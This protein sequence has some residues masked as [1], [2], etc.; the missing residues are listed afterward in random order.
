MKISIA[1][2]NLF[3]ERIRFLISVSGVAF[4]VM[5]ILILLGLYRGW[6]NKLGKYIEGVDADV[7]V[8]QNGAADMF[9]STSLIPNAVGEQL[10]KIEGVQSVHPLIGRRVPLRINDEETNTI[11]MGY[12]VQN[13]V[14]GP[15]EIVK[16]K[17]APQNGEII[18]DEVLA[19]TINKTIGETIDLID[20]PFTIVGISRGGNVVTFTYSFI[21]TDDARKLMQMENYTNYYLARFHPQAQSENIIQSIESSIPQLKVFRKPEFSENNRKQIVEVFLPIIF[22]LVIIGFIVGSMVI[23]LTIY[24]ATIEK[25]REYGILK[26]IGASSR[27][28]SSII[29]TQ[30]ALA[31][32]I[33]FLIGIGLTLITAAI[34]QNIEPNFITEISLPDVMIVFGITVLMIFFSAFIPL[35]RLLAIDP[36]IVFKA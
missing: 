22:V 14:G 8:L 16:G 13:K 12:D 33:G 21:T 28:L 36:A 24:T 26:A 1:R 5:L 35:R 23:S 7:W 25:S 27:H 19:K 2:K 30:S 29:F 20:L 11:V 32:F 34:V 17:T 18:I 15:L 6:N 9:H 4:S 10:A 3:H 31:G